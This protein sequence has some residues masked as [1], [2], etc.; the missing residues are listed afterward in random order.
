MPQPFERRTISFVV[1]LWLE[2]MPQQS[3]SH[4]RGQIEHVG[5]GEK[6]HFQVPAALL[7]FLA[8]HIEQLPPPLAAH[9]QTTP[10]GEGGEGKATIA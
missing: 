5:S 10:E 2:P 4:W 9:G 3:E 7:A 8:E 6:V 1:R